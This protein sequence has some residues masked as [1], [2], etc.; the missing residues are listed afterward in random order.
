MNNKLF[1]VLSLGGLIST[2][3]YA[4]WTPNGGVLYNTTQNIGIGT[5]TPALKFEMVSTGAGTSD[6]AQFTTYGTG[7]S[8]RL[9]LQRARGTSASPTDAAADDQVG[10]LDAQARINGAFRWVASIRMGVDASPGASSYPGFI[11]FGTSPTS[12]TAV[13]ERMRVTESGNVGIGTST[14]ITEKLY[15]S[16]NVLSTGD[17]LSGSGLFNVNSTTSNFSLK[18]N[19]TTRLTVLNSNGYVGIGSTATTPTEQLHVGGNILSSGNLGLG[20]TPSQKLH[21]SG[22]NVLIDNAGTPTIYTGTGA[23]ELN[24]YLLLMNSSGTSSTSGLKAGGVLVADATTYA[25]PGKND[26]VVKGKVAINTASSNYTLGVNGKIGARDLQ[27]EGTSWSDYV[28]ADDYELPTLQEV[29]K[30][31]RE[32]KHLSE[33]PSE[34]EVKE[35]GYSVKDLDVVL[36]KKVE[37]L[38]LYVIE[39]QKQIDDLK[40]KLEEKEKK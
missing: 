36:L 3:I 22:G 9:I 26:L 12:G 25:N 38:T 28:F 35:N 4:Q 17:F 6:L 14:G 39:Q 33:I 13:V 32:H 10:A 8:S 1:L 5:T 2:E 37:E 7:I 23:S 24:R 18:L 19:T 20:A 15:V 27:I 30:Y 40:K 21:I 31:I 16:G 34:A 29:E 11:A